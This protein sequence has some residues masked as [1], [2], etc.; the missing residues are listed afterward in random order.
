[1]K[2]ERSSLDHS[3]ELFI[4]AGESTA[5][6]KTELPQQLHWSAAIQSHL[7]NTYKPGI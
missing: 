2:A 5:P 7:P 3:A 4:R 1:M 6:R